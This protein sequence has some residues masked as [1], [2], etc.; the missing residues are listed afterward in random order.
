MTHY[1]HSQYIDFVYQTIAI[2]NTQKKNKK[3]KTKNKKT[4]L[5]KHEI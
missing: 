5:K 4:N 1:R 3:Q 2:D